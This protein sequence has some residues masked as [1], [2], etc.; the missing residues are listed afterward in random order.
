[1]TRPC[2]RRCANSQPEGSGTY[3]QKPKLDEN[4][5]GSVEL[6]FFVR[7]EGGQVLN[8]SLPTLSFYQYVPEQMRSIEINKEIGELHKKIC[9]VQGILIRVRDF[10]SMATEES[11]KYLLGEDQTKTKVFFS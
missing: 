2:F 6:S 7:G 9:T 8:H 5:C 11:A 4:G 10:G 3:F 1:M